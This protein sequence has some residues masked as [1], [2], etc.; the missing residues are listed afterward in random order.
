MEINQST[1]SELIKEVLDKTQKRFCQEL[2]GENDEFVDRALR[3]HRDRIAR[4]SWLAANKWCKFDQ[5][6][7]VL[8]PDGTRIYYR[9]GSTELLVQEFPPQVRLLKFKGSLVKKADSTVST[10]DRDY[11]KIY[12][13][14]LPLPYTIF[15]F[16]FVD[17]IFREVRCAFSDRP[18]KRLEEKPL[19]PYLS[20]ID[21]NLSVCLG[22]SFDK[23]QLIANDVAQQAALVLSHF[24]HSTFTDEWSAHYWA[25][26]ASFVKEDPRLATLEAWQNNGVE[27]PLF[28][29]EDV[30]WLNH[31]E[32][33]FGDMLLRMLD[34]DS[35]NSQFQEEL[36]QQISE[37]IIKD[38]IKTFNESV[39]AVQERVQKSLLDQLTQT[40]ISKLLPEAVIAKIK[41]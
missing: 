34:G 11:D 36:Y 17:G 22:I 4:I 1:I 23:S 31:T 26:K 7:P 15:I 21:S 19:R 18:L 20:N 2:S 30:A 25:S 32:E 28:V 3:L 6:G 14:S 8:M 27:N 39:D 13:F 40:V 24:W 33:S 16:K 10:S 12:H 41:S 29:I 5:D 38:V 37:D 35:I 9:K